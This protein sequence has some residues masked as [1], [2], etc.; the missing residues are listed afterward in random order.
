MGTEC[1]GG[2]TEQGFEGWEEHTGRTIRTPGLR[3]HASPSSLRVQYP[4]L[5][6]GE[7]KP[8]FHAYMSTSLENVL[9]MHP[10]PSNLC[11]L[12]KRM[13]PRL[14]PC[15]ES[16]LAMKLDLRRNFPRSPL[17]VSL[18]DPGIG[19]LFICL[20]VFYQNPTLGGKEGSQTAVRRGAE[21]LCCLLRPP[22]GEGRE[23]STG[24]QGR[25]GVGGGALQAPEET[26]VQGNGFP[27]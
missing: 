20:F 9:E 21:S 22:L 4:H 1:V 7:N 3:P 14:Q 13:H 18:K 17:C 24:S 12:E 6:T 23:L 2:R 27:R 25:R 19:C 8:F 5:N 16:C 26:P 11:S 15:T 10:A